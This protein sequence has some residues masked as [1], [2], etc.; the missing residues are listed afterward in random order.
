M[1]VKAADGINPDRGGLF[2]SRT[3]RYIWS[4]SCVQTGKV[5]YLLTREEYLD[6]LHSGVHIEFL[7]EHM[8]LNLY[9]VMAKNLSKNSAEFFM[10]HRYRLT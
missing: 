1:R 6:G 7:A 3:R 8:G 9:E 5:Y 4:A 10:N 2:S